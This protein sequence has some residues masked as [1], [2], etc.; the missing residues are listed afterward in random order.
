MKL[1]QAFDGFGCDSQAVARLLGGLDKCEA[2]AIAKLYH[3]KYGVCLADVLSAEIGDSDFKSAA[4]R[5]TNPNLPDP[6]GG[7]ESAIGYGPAAE[8]PISE[9][10]PNILASIKVFLMEKIRSIQYSCAHCYIEF[11]SLRE[12]NSFNF[13]SN[14]IFSDDLFI[15]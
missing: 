7:R 6:T 12:Y 8:Y 15:P 14:N 13:K 3:S 4:I 11:L 1:K 9:E 2:I 10:L 5:W